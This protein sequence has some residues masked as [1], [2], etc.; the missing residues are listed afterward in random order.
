MSQ[1]NTNTLRVLQKDREQTYHFPAWEEYA[2]PASHTFSN[3]PPASPLLRFATGDGGRPY[4]AQAALDKH[5]V[6]IS[7]NKSG[8]S[9]LAARC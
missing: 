7:G 1:H 9:A 3:L 2:M 6:A 8:L 4:H 5:R